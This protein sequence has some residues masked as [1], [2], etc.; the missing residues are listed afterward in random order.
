[1]L[2]TPPLSLRLHYRPTTLGRPALAFIE[3]DISRVVRALVLVVVRKLDSRL[4]ISF[5]VNPDLPVLDYRLTVGIAGMI[6][7]PRIVSVNRTVDDRF[8][9][10]REK[11]SVVTLHV[12]VIVPAVGFLIRDPLARVF[13]DSLSRTNSSLCKNSATLN[14]RLPNFIKP[15]PRAAI[16]CRHRCS[17]LRDG[18]KNHSPALTKTNLS[19]RSQNS[20][21]YHF[22][23]IFEKRSA[24]TGRQHYRIRAAASKL[25]QAAHLIW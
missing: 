15:V 1:V 14:F 19:L 7:Q 18:R 17:L 25:E 11:E 8:L 10:E 21:H 4:N 6:D 22:V 3:L 24:F 13:D 20:T 23:S 2:T 5:R 9:V 12:L 16:A